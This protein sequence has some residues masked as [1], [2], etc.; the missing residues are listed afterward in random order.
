[1][2]IRDRFRIYVQNFANFDRTYG[3]I[4]GIIALL[5]W[6]YGTMFVVLS[7]GELAAELAHGTGAV[8]PLRGA[9]YHGRVVS[10][11]DSSGGWH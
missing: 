2:C 9:I 10:V 7:G 1:M 6:M 8:R 3:T 11:P 4:G 5:T